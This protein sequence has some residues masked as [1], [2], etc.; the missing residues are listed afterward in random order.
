MKKIIS[1]AALILSLMP[2]AARADAAS[3]AKC[4]DNFDLARDAGKVD[5][6]L[7]LHIKFKKPG[8]DFNA[9]KG[10]ILAYA[11]CRTAAQ[12][13]PSAC[14]QAGPVKNVGDAVK[15]CAESYNRLA[16]WL[17]L[18]DGEAAGR[19]ECASSAASGVS[20]DKVCATATAGWKSRQDLCSMAVSLLNPQ[21]LAGCSAA[22]KQMSAKKFVAANK[23]D[24][25]GWILHH[26]WNKTTPSCDKGLPGG[27]DRYTAALRKGICYGIYA[28]A[29]C[30]QLVAPAKTYYCA[31]Q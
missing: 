17:S 21:A 14:E 24:F 23:D 10:G 4:A 25:D 30:E 8:V 2:S 26:L 5:E 27:P 20:P 22:Y 12:R 29:R 9:L 28:P 16:F 7:E 11:A 15:Q 1:I 13:D 18:E 31:V 3:A 19:P 6:L